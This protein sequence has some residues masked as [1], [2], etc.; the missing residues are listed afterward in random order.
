MR[1]S[2]TSQ[3]MEIYFSTSDDPTP[4]KGQVLLREGPV[5]SIQDL[6]PTCPSLE[7]IQ[8]SLIPIIEYNQVRNVEETYR[9]L[10]GDVLEET[11]GTRNQAKAT[12]PT[13]QEA[14][15][16]FIKDDPEKIEK[17]YRFERKCREWLAGKGD[18]I[19]KKYKGQETESP[20]NQVFWE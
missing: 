15:Y 3:K 4:R 18:R 8:K 2:D 20:Y 1:L 10:I 12:L 7:Y 6:G 14:M 11:K 5:L 13:Y 9:K 17:F 16:R 19:S